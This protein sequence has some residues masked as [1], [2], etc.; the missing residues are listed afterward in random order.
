MNNSNIY[1]DYIDDLPIDKYK[2]QSEVELELVRT[3]FKKSQQQSIYL[4][5]LNQTYEPLLVGCIFLI[6]TLPYTDNVI[7]SV[8]PVTNDNNLILFNLYNNIK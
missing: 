1:Y 8:F 4:S 2:K 3:L 5:M 7:K 6:F